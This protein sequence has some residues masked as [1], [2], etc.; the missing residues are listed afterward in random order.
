MKKAVNDNKIKK[1][2]MK[3]GPL[4]NFKAPD[5]DFKALED[6]LKRKQAEEFMYSQ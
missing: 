3:K 2:A 5:I 1:E 4:N 6:S